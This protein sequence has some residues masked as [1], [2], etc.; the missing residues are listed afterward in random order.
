MDTTPHNNV[1]PPGIL[2]VGLISNPHSGR[3]RKHLDTIRKIVTDYPNVHHRTT[4]TAD[5]I[6]AVLEAFAR[7]PVDILAINGGDGTIARILTELLER[8]P[9]P[10]L[11]RL[12]LLP[13]GTTNMNAA[14]VGLR[15]NLVKAIRRLCTW[16][17]GAPALPESLQRPVLRVTGG[18]GQA[19]VCGMAFGAGAITRGVEYSDTSINRKGIV[20][21]FRPALALF[22]TLWG[23]ASR[24]RRF[25]KPVAISLQRDNEPADPACDILILIIS[26]LER[27]MLGSRPF[28]GQES[29]PLHTSLVHAD[30]ERFLR[31]LP[32]LVRGKPNRHMTEANG[33]SSHNASRIRLAMDGSWMLDG[34]VHEARI[35]DGPVT[36]SNGGDVTFVRL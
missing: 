13:G 26:S 22:R 10:V 23:L 31:N 33:Y 18:D 25:F 16:S 3:N 20:G 21:A 5:D 36:I 6:P 28:W 7:Q 30:A 17:S 32:A 24:D 15:G 27:L 14:D 8:G 4:Q 35:S 2:S 9:F 11:P 12:A 29:A 19:A 34:E 1:Q